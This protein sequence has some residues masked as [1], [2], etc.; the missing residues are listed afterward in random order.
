MRLLGRFVR[1]TTGKVAVAVLVTTAVAVPASV[2]AVTSFTDV[3]TSHPFYKEIKAVAEAGIAQ[4]FG[5]GGYHPSANV[6]RQA[7]AA[8]LERGVGRAVSNN[9]TGYVYPDQSAQIAAVSMDAGAAGAGTDGF[10]HVSGAA[11]ATT[12]DSSTTDCI[13]I[14]E[15]AIYD[16]NQKIAL[17]YLEVP[18]LLDGPNAL[19]STNVE[20]VLQVNGDSTHL[21]RLV[22]TGWNAYAQ[23][24]TTTGSITA[25]YFA[26]SGDG[27]STANYD[28]T[29]AKDD[30]W[31]PNNDLLTASTY[32]MA[33][34]NSTDAIVCPGDDDFYSDS[35]QEG[36]TVSVTVDFVHAEGDIDVCLYHGSTQVACSTGITDQESISYP[37]AEAGT[38]TVQVY[39]VVDYGSLLGNTYTL[40]ATRSVLF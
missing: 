2:W 40:S 10:V 26:L 12:P 27:D 38:Y 14:I 8:F 21:Y 36:A 22:A 11:W 3:P 23:Q 18:L 5:D 29:C 25:T 19:A 35:V 20:T 4:G 24:V 15:V 30:A 9:G 17:S 33:S 28:L 37:D 39:V 32:F 13:C 16:G 6:T 7:M 1:S 31:E 34:G